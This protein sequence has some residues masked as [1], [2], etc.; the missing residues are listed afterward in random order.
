MIDT[1]SF[2]EKNNR[3]LI[4][5][6]T[7]LPNETVLLS[8]HTIEEMERAICSLQ[9][10][11]APAIGVAAAIGLAVLAREIRGTYETVLHDYAR[12]LKATRPTA[13]NLA[14]AIDRM[15][16]GPQDAES[17]AYQALE[18]WREDIATCR[19]IGEYSSA[20]L[21]DGDCVLTHCNAGRL[22][23]VRY[24]TALAPVYI[25]HENG[26]KIHVF[27]DETRPLLQGARLTAYELRESGIDVTLICDNMAAIL[28]QSGKI[29]SVFIGADRISA[30]GDA[31]NKV[32][33]LGLSI[34][35]RHF[36]V[37]F[38]V[39]APF[40]TIDFDCKDGTEIPIEQRE[41][42][43]ITEMWYQK[44]MAPS[45]IEVFNPAF[46]VVLA[47]NVTAFVT[48]RGVIAPQDLSQYS[49]CQT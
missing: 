9:V 44:P 6:Q 31:A 22:A 41:G 10:R 8:L 34:L 12:R 13:V 30:N 48:E 21:R 26:K 14:W 19:K 43:E 4:I 32:G 7:K 27:A 3:L 38:Y 40:S 37:P 17:L 5:D 20:L 49:T 1:V 15:L 29:S 23:A 28:L 36:E 35:A 46:D 39:C 45:N 33:S 11:G 47:Q 24:G 18:L 16:A 2:D 25:A 42:A